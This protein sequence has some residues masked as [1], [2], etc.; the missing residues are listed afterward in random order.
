[1]IPSPRRI[2]PGPRRRAPWLPACVVA[3][4][5]AAAAGACKGPSPLPQRPLLDI[6]PLSIAFL[7]T[8]ADPVPDSQSIDV[9]EQ[10]GYPLASAPA[11][12]I[13]SQTPAKGWLHWRVTPRPPSRVFSV[14][15]DTNIDQLPLP[16]GTYT[17][18][19]LIDAKG[20]D[21]VPATVTVTLTV[22]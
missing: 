21:G 11:V 7:S 17:T 16:P 8:P 1:M 22:R 2:A 10:R 5:A 12:A 14:V 18:E 4:A 19:L 13:L 9:L 20:A 6:Q 15:L 3:L